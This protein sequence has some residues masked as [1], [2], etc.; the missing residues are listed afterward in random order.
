MLAGL[1]RPLFA[2]S[3]NWT[4]SRLPGATQG[5]TRIFAMD[6]AALLLLVSSVSVAFGWQPMSDGSQRYEYVVQ[7]EPE[8]AKTLADGQAIP[9]VS[10]VPEQV[11]PIGRI[12]L[13][14][15][16]EALPRQ[17]LTT[18]LKPAN[19]G[20]AVGQSGVALA[21]YN[22]QPYGDQRYL[23]TPQ[24]QGPT[25]TQNPGPA[26]NPYA[27]TQSAAQQDGGSSWN[28]QQDE[29]P[30]TPTE[31]GPPSGQQRFGEASPGAATWNN[32]RTLES[33]AAEMAAAPLNRVGQGLQ[34]AVDPLKRGIERLDSEVRGAADNLGDRT[35]SLV[36]ELRQP[37]QQP[38]LPANTRPLASTATPTN[39]Q[40]WNQEGSSGAA[41]NPLRDDDSQ[42][43]PTW[44]NAAAAPPAETRT[45]APPFANNE[46]PKQQSASTGSSWNDGPDAAVN[47]QL[48]KSAPGDPWAGVPDP[49][50]RAGVAG[51]SSGSPADVPG[52]ATRPLPFGGLGSNQSVMGPEFP[53]LG[54]GQPQTAGSVPSSQPNTD[55]AVTSATAPPA[56]VGARMLN[57]PADRPLDGV[58]SQHT[59]AT[60][61]VASPA[62]INRFPANPAGASQATHPAPAAAAPSLSTNAA[63][64]A[65]RDNTVAVLAA[66]VLLSG[67]VAGNMYLFWSYLDV[68]QKYRALVRKTARAVGS[69]FSAA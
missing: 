62:N 22:Q 32:G 45:Q 39:A 9:I 37:F 54:A 52:L 69:R 2:L 60:A 46:S 19:D 33:A 25:T 1:S 3:L 28:S 23:A 53:N 55:P 13:V 16:R 57:Q 48:S 34:Q 61:P 10:D 27:P 12:R 36:D 51:S 40:A 24:K 64:P 67:S 30:I 42:P 49:R 50:P 15:G 68:R 21:Q 58:P 18:R 31:S 66:W 63:A 59:A 11:Q 6:G 17:R 26:G 20:S 44:N 7:V 56:A 41:H 38:Q 4:H 5:C 14:V 47:R 29:P 43:G 8:L 35:K 65:P